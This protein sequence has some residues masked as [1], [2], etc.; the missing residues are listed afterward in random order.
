MHQEDNSSVFSKGGGGTFYEISVQTAFVITLLTRGKLP[1]FPTGDLTDIAFQT[2]RLGF[3]TDDILIKIQSQHREH[4]V[5]VQAKHNLT[6]SA[7]DSTFGKVMADFWQDFSNTALFQSERDRLLIVKSGLTLNDRR[8]FVVLLDWA[9]S[10]VSA[11]D[12]FLE[13]NRITR[14][15]TALKVFADVL[16]KANGGTAL[17]SE[18]LWQFLRCLVLI[19]YDFGVESSTSQTNFLN[20]IS[21]AKNRLTSISAKEIWDS[22]FEFTGRLNKDGGN[23]TLNSIQRESFA[24][25]FEPKQ[26]FESY[27]AIKKLQEDSQTILGPM[28]NNIGGLHLHRPELYEQ[29]ANAINNHTITIVAGEPGVGKSALVKELVTDY[30]SASAVLIFKA[31]QFNQPYVG[32]V[33]SGL[34]IS[35]GLSQ[36]SACLAAISKKVI[37]IDSFEKLLEGE[38]D[39]AFRQFIHLV[40][41]VNDIRIIATSRTYAVDL[42]TLKYALEKVAIVE[43]PLLTETEL[44]IVSGKFPKLNPLL[45]NQQIYQV[46][47]SPKYLEYTVQ[48]LSVTNEQVSAFTLPDFKNRLWQH[49]VENYL[50]TRNG[51]PAKRGKAFL[52]ITLK[53]AQ[54]M[55]LYAT[56]EQADAEAIDELINDNVV[57]KQA[58]E[59]KYSPSHDILEDWALVKHIRKIRENYPEP[60]SFYQQIGN[61]PALR[62]AFRLWVE[63]LLHSQTGVIFKLVSETRQNVAIENYWADELL[64]A[65]LRSDAGN[66]FFDEFKSALLENQAQF[67]QRT[68]HL[69]HTACKEYRSDFQLFHPV[70]SGWSASLI[71]I[72]QHLLQLS[73]FRRLITNLVIEWS[74]KLEGNRS[75][76]PLFEIDAAKTI[77]F[78]YLKEAENKEDYWFDD[79]L[80]N[81]IKPLIDLAFGLTEYAQNEVKEI[82]E[83]AL[84]GPEES[85]DPHDRTFYGQIRKMTLSGHYSRPLTRFLPQQVIQMAKAAWLRKPRPENKYFHS[86]FDIN[87]KYGLENHIGDFPPGIYKIPV[88]NLL[89]NNWQQGID[90]ALEIINHCTDYYMQS[91]E[92]KEDGAVQI[93]LQL[94]DGQQVSQWGSHILWQAYRGTTVSSYLLESILM[95]LEEYLLKMA[96]GEND[97]SRRNIR[98]V[99]DYLLRDSRS[100]AVSSVLVSVAIAYPSEVSEAML[101]LLGVKEFY[102]WDYRRATDDFAGALAIRDDEIP[103]AQKARHESNQ[104]PHRK[105][106]RDGLKGFMLDLQF[107]LQLFNNSLFDLFDKLW[108]E[109]EDIYWRKLLYEI[110]ARKWGITDSQI[111][112]RTYMI[113]PNYDSDIQ[114]IVDDN[115]PQHDFIELTAT[116]AAWIRSVYEKKESTT[117]TRWATIYE[118]YQEIEN[119]NFTFDRPVTLA[120]IGLR[121][122]N[123]IL[124][125]EQQTWCFTTIVEAINLLIWSIEQRHHHIDYQLVLSPFDRE[126]ALLSLPFLVKSAVS[127]ENQQIAVELLFRVL[128]T[129]FA[130]HEIEP[131]L[132]SIREEL[133]EVNTTIANHIWLGLLRF[134]ELR[135]TNDKKKWLAHSDEELQQQIM[136]G[137]ETFI[138]EVVLGK[139]RGDIDFQQIKLTTWHSHLLTRALL[140]LPFT[141]KDK[142]HLD[143]R[144]FFVILFFKGLNE[145]YLCEERHDRRPL[146]Y[147]DDRL[148]LHNYI[149]NYFLYCDK[150]DAAN[151]TELLLIHVSAIIDSR[152]F[153][154]DNTVKYIRWI[155]ESTIYELDK[156]VH[157][158]NDTVA[159]SVMLNFWR[160]WERFYQ[161]LHQSGKRVFFSLLFL[162]IEWNEDCSHWKPVEGKKE[163]FKRITDTFGKHDI[164]PLIQLLAT[165]GGQTLLPEGL[166]WVVELIKKNPDLV[167]AL[168]SEKAE[169]LI[170]RIYQQHIS[171]IKTDVLLLDDFIWL[172]DRM[173][174]LGSS[175]AY[176]TREN[177]I[178]YKK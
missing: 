71:F 151:L 32:Q 74:Y 97:I 129:Y 12:F 125:S 98:F 92:S 24:S 152:S 154:G 45:A 106:Y 50:V 66:I 115:Q 109:A 113:R 132:V 81:K 142:L 78:F 22:V 150:E 131:V 91:E 93:Q 164:Q 2:T 87:R 51:M 20:L 55:S 99:F 4:N 85:Y 60:N 56:T 46:L 69:L 96:A 13:V 67:L 174:D 100:V 156:I 120:I 117:Y 90:F 163:F 59:S 43:V 37:V 111:D 108:Q 53:R 136:L 139:T 48:W 79:H 47:R 15:Q 107:N 160:V 82:L 124:T 6:L 11:D 148:L 49:I 80:Q 121:D 162:Q 63:D 165:V 135:Q 126:A 25:Y 145:N 172:L 40:S 167:S 41:H 62:R 8:D 105:K 138:K 16:Q 57:I 30:A 102:E 34:G 178:T 54:Q 18:R 19:E 31:D 52:E 7:N 39:N 128:I 177:L 73:D 133:W 89:R 72:Q 28:K 101:P 116:D 153:Y 176:I 76:I 27:A 149:K 114:K 38:P 21:L 158:F 159:Q 29:L 127:E 65:I 95:S 169:V 123:T 9:K 94:S 161:V 70:G 140:I 110:D 64:I 36:L 33:F 61:K 146:V 14:K 83:R 112:E 173:V 68:I 137:E 147:D 44:E 88:Y 103:Y 77:I 175:K 157:N 166:H 130:K 58:E 119:V 171:S 35:E 134:A 86:P 3:A 1:G 144:N 143:Y 122:L 26:L 75:T 141:T 84:A 168:G 17:P 118:R 104:L 170:S 42:L 155:F 23:I 10:K 5:L